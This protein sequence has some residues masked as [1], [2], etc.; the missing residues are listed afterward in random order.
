MMSFGSAQRQKRQYKVIFVNALANVPHLHWLV[1]H[2]KTNKAKLTNKK[3]WKICLVFTKTGCKL[4][5][6]L[7]SVCSRV[8]IASFRDTTIC[9]QLPLYFRQKNSMETGINRLNLI[10]MYYPPWSSQT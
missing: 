5:P 7:M 10:K 1:L 6:E 3:T 2:S 8:A 9:L 4:H